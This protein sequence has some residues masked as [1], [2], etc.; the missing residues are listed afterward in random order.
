MAP[1]IHMKMNWLSYLMWWLVTIN[2]HSCPERW[3]YLLQFI[4]QWHGWDCA[5]P[6]ICRF[7]SIN[8]RIVF[9]PQLGVHGCGGSRVFIDPFIILLICRRHELPRILVAVG[10]LWTNPSWIPRVI[11]WGSQNLSAEFQFWVV[12]LVPLNPE[13]FRS[14]LY[15]HLQRSREISEQWNITQL[16]GVRVRVESRSCWLEDLCT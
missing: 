15:P 3:V 11:V 16:V 14:P 7:F 9:D 2:P 8:G 6:H 13:L 1:Q 4:L 5:G 12:V 10:I